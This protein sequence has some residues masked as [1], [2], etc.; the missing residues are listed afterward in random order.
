MR[1]INC[2][3]PNAVRKILID[4]RN[5]GKSFSAPKLAEPIRTK[6]FREIAY[7]G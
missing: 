6:N 4:L 5:E 2:E 3:I 1:E 7:T